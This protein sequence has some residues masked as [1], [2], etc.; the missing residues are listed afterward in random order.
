MS[1]ELETHF[2]AAVS[3]RYGADVEEATDEDLTVSTSNNQRD[4]SKRWEL[5]G[6]EKVK[7][8]QC[9]LERLTLVALRGEHI[10]KAYKDGPGE[11]AAVCPRIQELDVR[12]TR[13]PN[14]SELGKIVAELPSAFSLDISENRQLAG[15]Q[16][17]AEY[18]LASGMPAKAF[19]NLKVLVLNDT[20]IPWATLM[21]LVGEQMTSL[22]ELHAE[23]NGFA[24]LPAVTKTPALSLRVLNLNGNLLDSFE[25]LL[26]GLTSFPKLENLVLTGNPVKEFSHVRVL[27][28]AVPCL[29]A[30]SIQNMPELFEGSP[31]AE[32][33]WH[34]HTLYETFPNLSA[35]KVSYEDFFAGAA[36]YNSTTCRLTV[37]SQ[38]PTMTSL[39]GSVVRPKERS[40]AQKYYLTRALAECNITDESGVPPEGKFPHFQRYV[41]EHGRPAKATAGAATAVPTA[42]STVSVTFRCAASA[43]IGKADSTKAVPLGTRVA[44]LKSIAKNLFG[45][46]VQQQSLMCREAVKKD[47]AHD[48][49]SASMPLL[50]DLQDM[51]F[52]NIQDGAIIEVHDA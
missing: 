33:H 34:L 35:L 19:G 48:E 47:E 7:R 32:T 22:Q 3:R 17:D 31:D 24:C 20:Q 12:D 29:R 27:K 9:N 50:D 8:K 28:D 44:Q 11:I 45:I 39:N 52:Y 10:T 15:S 16:V 13:V 21:E 46:D 14:W 25:R 41:A 6:M 4:R 5:V 42:R 18:F 23:A 36:R 2:V 37:T 30:L 26:P 40:D 49:I 1:T 38:I 51:L 43:G